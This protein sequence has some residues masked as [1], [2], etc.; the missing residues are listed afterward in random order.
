[1]SYTRHTHMCVWCCFSILLQ[2]TTS[3]VTQPPPPPLFGDTVIENGGSTAQMAV[4]VT[5]HL[6]ITG[7]EF[8]Q[9]GTSSSNLNPC[10]SVSRIRWQPKPEGYRH[11][12]CITSPPSLW[13]G[14]KLI[15]NV[16]SSLCLSS[17]A[18]LF[19]HGEP[20]TEQGLP[21]RQL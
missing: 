10:V 12:V 4:Y 1:M 16:F 3:R 11:W 13:S 7:S 21:E 8:A 17:S 2:E 6:L 14:P 18:S 19:S 15:L 5:Y 20:A 9:G